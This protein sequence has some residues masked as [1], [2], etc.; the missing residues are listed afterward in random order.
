MERFDAHEHFWR[1]NAERDKWITSDM[2]ILQRDFLP[3][4]LAPIFKENGVNGCI[5]VQAAQ[6]EEENKF[7]LDL[8]E[9]FDFI[10]GVVGWIDLQDT[11]IESKLA[12]WSIHKKLCGFRHILQAE[13]APFMLQPAFLRGVAALAKFDFSFDI[14]VKPKHLNALIKFMPHFSSSQR[15]VIDHLA[16]P[17]IKEGRHEP[18]AAN[19]KALA[20]FPNLYCKLS[21]MITEADWKTWD[22]KHFRFYVRHLLDVFG[23]KR[24]M[25]GSDWPVCLLAGSYNQVITLLDVY[26]SELTASERAMI[27]SR[28]A[29]E[30]YR[31]KEY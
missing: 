15:F 3:E 2:G 17:Y 8:A 19:M 21:G 20:A 24:L 7:L 27:W 28:N 31:I 23:P 12:K 14:L 4:H 16:K 26:L 22:V 25:F 13:E 1:F 6:S 11:L 18:W 5:A 9:Q 30:F 29:E 10:K